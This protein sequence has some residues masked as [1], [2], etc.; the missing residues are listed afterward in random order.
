MEWYFCYTD[1]EAI[2]TELFII[3]LIIIYIIYN[4]YNNKISMNGRLKNL[5][6]LVE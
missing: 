1:K 2:G 6:V 3:I 5:P 4:I